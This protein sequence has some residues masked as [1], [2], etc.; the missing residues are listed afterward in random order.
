MA[1]QG[2]LLTILAGAGVGFVGGLYLAQTYRLPRVREAAA[3][4]WTWAGEE[5]DKH[6]KGK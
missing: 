6:K 5:A 3:D 2:P 4:L 1:G